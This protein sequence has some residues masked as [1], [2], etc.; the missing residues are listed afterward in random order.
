VSGGYN[1]SSVFHPVITSDNVQYLIFID[2]SSDVVFRKS[3]DGGLNYDAPVV[4]FAGTAIGLA[5]WYDKWSGLSTGLI[6]VA[7]TQDVTDDTLYRTID[8]ANSDALSTQTTIFAGTSA[9]GAGHISIARM[10]GGNV[11]CKTCIDA[12]VEGGFFRLPNANVP[13]GAWDAARTINEALAAA[14]KMIIL[15]GF[16]ADNQDAIGIFWD[17]SASQISRQ[18]YDDSANTWAETSIA[19]GMTGLQ[20]AVAGMNFSATV[21][22]ANSRIIMVAWSAT[23]AANA[24]LRCWTITESAITETSTNVV[25]NSTDDQ[26]LCAI[27]LDTVNDD[28]YVFYCGKSDGS[29]TWTTSLSVQYKV[30]T[31]A[32][33]TWSAEQTTLATLWNTKYLVCCPRIPSSKWVV[34]LY[35]L[36]NAAYQAA[37][38]QPLGHARAQVMLGV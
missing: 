33:A 30:S 36:V 20:A 23:D 17:N 2:A 7:Y 22:L 13:N 11:L 14:D 15:P 16:A 3:T 32:G 4:I 27:A 21:D 6:H 12:G 1:F 28:W 18:L 8:T 10:R 25:L 37:V 9:A 19:T 24:D 35:R 38:L 31:D 5:V 34:Q 26:G 29:E